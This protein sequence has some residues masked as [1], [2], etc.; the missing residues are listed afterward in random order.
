ME[1]YIR[2]FKKEGDFLKLYIKV[3]KFN[4]NKKINIMREYFRTK[5]SDNFL[6]YL[7]CGFDISCKYIILTFVLRNRKDIEQYE[8]VIKKL[9]QKIKLLENEK[10][11]ENG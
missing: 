9:E 1:D 6:S 8:K 7:G 3:P 11:G 4:K 5:Y 2:F 10:E